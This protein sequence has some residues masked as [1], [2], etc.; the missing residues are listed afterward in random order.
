MWAWFARIVAVGAP[1]ATDIIRNSAPTLLSTSALG[2]LAAT[3]IAIRVKRKRDKGAPTFRT[4][5]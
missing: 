1:I 2:A 4:R 5:Q 3:E